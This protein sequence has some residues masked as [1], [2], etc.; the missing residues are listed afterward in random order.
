MKRTINFGKVDYNRS[1]RRNCEVTID[2]EVED[3]NV[4]I[5]GTVWNPRRTDA[6]S[7]GQNLDTIAKLLPHNKRVRRIVEIWRRWHL[8]DLKAGCEHQRAAG[9]DKLP[10]DP[11]QPTNVYGR[12]FPEQKQASWNMLGWV[13]PDEHPQGL[14]TKACPECGYKYGTEWKRE[15]VPADVLAELEAI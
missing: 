1:G 14:L 12:F 10:I 11:S 4:S 3:G 5:C 8:N 15:E 9:W 2:V 7:C 13:R 6:Y